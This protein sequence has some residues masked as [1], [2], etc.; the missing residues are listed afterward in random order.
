[1]RTQTRAD[2]MK[3]TGND[4]SGGNVTVWRT[5]SSEGMTA[6]SALPPSRSSDRGRLGRD[7]R[8]GRKVRGDDCSLADGALRA[9]STAVRFNE[10]LDDCEPQSG[11]ARLSVATCISAVEPLENPL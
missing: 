9:R 11:S 1:M 5:M 8:L 4:E 3:G 2:M 7:S 6:P 10:M